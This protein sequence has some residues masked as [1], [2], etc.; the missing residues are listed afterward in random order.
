MLN[1]AWK[2]CYSWFLL[3]LILIALTG[4]TYSKLLI[5]ELEHFSEISSVKNKK[6]RTTLLTPFSRNIDC[7]SVF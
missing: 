2:L 4:K 1:Y 5:K 6:L 3:L 7:F